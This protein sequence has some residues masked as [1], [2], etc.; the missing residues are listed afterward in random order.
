MRG[1]SK[2]FLDKMR[3]KLKKGREKGRTDYDEDWP[4]LRTDAHRYKR[5]KGVDGFLMCRLQEEVLELA[6]AIDRHNSDDVM[7]EAADVANLA[8]LIADL[9]SK[10]RE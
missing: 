4:R 9:Y 10:P 2:A 7:E 5:F 6:I 8:M 3:Q 1:L